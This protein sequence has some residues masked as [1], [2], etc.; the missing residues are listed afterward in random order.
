MIVPKD[1]G[2]CD[3][4]ADSDN[5]SD[6]NEHKID[7]HFNILWLE[8]IHNKEEGGG[9]KGWEEDG[10]NEGDNNLVVQR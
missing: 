1:N 3:N 4:T 6:E 7:L 5:S 10:G 2:D 8:E 9:V